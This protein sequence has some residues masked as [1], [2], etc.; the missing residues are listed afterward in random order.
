M[1]TQRI[2][3]GG[4]YGFG[5]LGDEALLLALLNKLRGCL[6]DARPVVLSQDPTRTTS[7]Y[8]VEAID[9]WSFSKIWQELK[10]TELF[11]FGGGGLLQ[12][13]T[14]L[15]S[16][17]YYLWLIRMAQMRGVP[18][19]LL[20]Q[21]I[22]PL[23]SR[24]LQRMT[25]RRLK[26]AEYIMVRDE[27]SLE[28]LKRWG[29]D[30]GQVVRGYDLALGLELEQ[31][32]VGKSDLLAVSLREVPGWNRGRF[33]TEMAAALDEVR[34]RLGLRA[35]FIPLHLQHDLKLTEEV[36]AAMAEESLELNLSGLKVSEALQL[37]AQ[38]RLM[39]GA[40]LHALEFSLVTGIPFAA[41][42]YDPKVDQ[43]VRLVEQAA[44][45]ME[46]PLLKATEVTKEGLLAALE[47]LWENKENYR[48]RLGEVALKLR[49]LADSS[50]KEACKRVIK[51]LEVEQTRRKR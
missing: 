21:G 48:K 34:R 41:L 51:T 36:R 20:G 47:S 16:A 19:F 33:I 49:E 25:A 4:Y 9:R 50:L 26:Q 1:A 28:L 5:N 40:R 44:E 11:I 6:P 15:R 31:G 24:F 37:L 8:V 22:G 14:S 35:A 3:I 27:Q 17:L 45:G 30:R 7:E 43:F 23:R 29:A 38:A 39:L 32:T 12:D 46:P 2:L 18:V 10:G 13:V 42:S